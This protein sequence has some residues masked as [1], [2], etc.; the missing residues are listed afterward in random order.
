[1]NNAD[2]EYLRLCEDILHNGTPKEDRTGTGTLS[3]FGRQLRFDLSEGF[4]LLTTKRVPFRLI[5]EELLFFVA[6]KTNLKDLLD[7]DVDIWTRDGM[8]KA[9]REE[10]SFGV[11]GYEEWTL[12]SF[13][14]YASHNDFDLG[15]IYGAQW[16]SWPDYTAPTHNGEYRTIDQLAIALQELKYNPDS[17]RMIVSA[18][19]PAE[20]SE[21]ALPPCHIMFQFYVAEGRLSLQMYQRSADVF[22]G[23]P[24]NIASYALLLEM[25][26]QVTGLDVGELIITLGDAHIYTNHISQVITQLGRE[27]KELPELMLASEI[28]EIDDFAMDSFHIVG[29]RPHGALKGE[30]SF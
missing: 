28:T 8:A 27:P 23:L 16:R 21:M 3:V 25:V 20:L 5:A 13:R 7:V 24:F 14:E 18:W 4:P 2:K 11:E 22:L 9:N 19:N 30:Q 26:A 15:P 6:G 12:D 17:R 29:Y 10:P 1:M